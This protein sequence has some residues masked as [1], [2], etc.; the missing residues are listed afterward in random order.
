MN[1]AFSLVDLIF[2]GIAALTVVC[3]LYAVVSRNIVRA[4]FSMLGTFLG[5]AGLYAMLAADFVAV[6]QLMVYVGGILVLMIF[7]VMLT[8]HIEQ[9]S[10]SN[11]LGKPVNLVVGLLLGGVMMAMLVIVAIKAPWLQSTPADYT[12]TTAALGEALL[13]QAL[14]PFELMSVVLLGVVIGSVVVARRQDE[15]PDEE[16]RR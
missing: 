1:P 5:V 12:P 14:L 9:A 4:V 3:G 16:V 6:V 10:R 15:M 2:Y 13:G 7:A 8:S 11:P